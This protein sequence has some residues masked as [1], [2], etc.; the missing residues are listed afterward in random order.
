MERTHWSTVALVAAVAFALGVAVGIRLFSA[1][2]PLSYLAAVPVVIV[3]LAVLGTGWRVRSAVAKNRIGLDRSQ[4][5]PHEV[6]VVLALAKA[7]S[8][9]GAALC[10]VGAGYAVPVGLRAGDVTA[11][12]A[13]LPVAIVL[14]VLGA[15]LC[16]VGLLVETWCRVP[17]GDDGETDS[18]RGAS[19]A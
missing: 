1:M 12:S 18:V 7:S 16:G 10:G 6:V 13:D 15:A 14:A 3:L 5:S 4:M 11:A 9:L 19:R 17:P 8:V 2:P